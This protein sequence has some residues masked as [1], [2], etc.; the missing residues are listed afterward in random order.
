MVSMRIIRKDITNISLLYSKLSAVLHKLGGRKEMMVKSNVLMFLYCF[1]HVTS[2]L[3]SK[4]QESPLLDSFENRQHMLLFLLLL[5]R[6]MLVLPPHCDTSKRLKSIPQKQKQ[7]V[8]DST[9]IIAF[10]TSLN[11]TRSI[12]IGFFTN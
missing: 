11:G 12:L 6:A 9:A 4:L 3:P 8:I 5:T 10:K 7:H 2:H 1:P